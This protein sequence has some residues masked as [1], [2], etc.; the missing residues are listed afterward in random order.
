M[1]KHTYILY[2]LKSDFRLNILMVAGTTIPGLRWQV[3]NE[4]QSGR[5]YDRET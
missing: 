2:I 4:A 1:L 3:G 5:E